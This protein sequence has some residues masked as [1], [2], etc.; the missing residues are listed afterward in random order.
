MSLK[1]RGGAK[2]NNKLKPRNAAGAT[3]DPDALAKT[4]MKKVKGTCKADAEAA[5]LDTAK[6]KGQVLIYTTQYAIDLLEK[7]QEADIDPDS[8]VVTTLT[9]EGYD[10]CLYEIRRALTLHNNDLN[11]ARRE[12]DKRVKIWTAAVSK[13][14]TAFQQLTGS[15]GYSEFAT[16]RA[17]AMSDMDLKKARTILEQQ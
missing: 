8:S 7:I 1:L 2:N 16:C 9:G 13:D 11:K 12:L 3:V 17:L 4:V 14:S 5:L 15:E 10:G 6:P